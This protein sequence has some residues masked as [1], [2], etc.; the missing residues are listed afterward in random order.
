MFED[1]IGVIIIRK[2]PKN[3]KQ[4]GQKETYKKINNDLQRK[5]YARKHR[6]LTKLLRALVVQ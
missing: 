4:N 3:R 2:S 5:Y 6:S 1:T